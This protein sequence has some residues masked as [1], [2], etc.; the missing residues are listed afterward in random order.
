MSV[1]RTRSTAMFVA[2]VRIPL[3]AV[4]R[5]LEELARLVVAAVRGLQQAV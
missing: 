3:D 5:R 2:A 4:A 1:S